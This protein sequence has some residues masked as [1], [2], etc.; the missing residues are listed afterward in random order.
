MLLNLKI[1]MLFAISIH[2]FCLASDN[3]DSCL[4]RLPHSIFA[5]ELRLQKFSS[6][7]RLSECLAKELFSP[8]WGANKKGACIHISATVEIEVCSRPNFVFFLNLALLH[9]KV[10]VTDVYRYIV[11]GW[12]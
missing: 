2:I 4:V 6:Q 8:Q 12:I 7:F 5:Y 3:L 11:Y 10:Y 1:V 9:K